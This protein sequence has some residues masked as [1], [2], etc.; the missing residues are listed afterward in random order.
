M[1]PR[2]P[3]GPNRFNQREVTRA[4]RAAHES[5]APVDRVEVDP[6]TGKIS[7][8]LAKPGGEAAA[9]TVNEWDEVGQ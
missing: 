2:T 9:D 3:R 4:V 1:A 7:V 6:A 5:G 8:I